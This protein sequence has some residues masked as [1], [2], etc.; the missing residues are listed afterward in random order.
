M[1]VNCFSDN[2]KRNQLD[3]CLNSYNLFRTNDFPTKIYSYSNL[4]V[5]NIFIDI[6]RLNNYQV[7]PL[8]NGLSG[9]DAQNII[10]NFLQNKPHEHQPY[11]GRNINNEPWQNSRI[12]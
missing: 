1:C 5:D 6:T 9:H 7:F 12:V 3:A 8:I 4:V 2:D 10:L 11:F